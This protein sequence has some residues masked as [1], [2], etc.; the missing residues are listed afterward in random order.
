MPKMEI[1]DIETQNL[2]EIYNKIDNFIKTL[3]KEE[4]D[5]NNLNWYKI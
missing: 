2:L 1:K 4:N 3:D 5:A